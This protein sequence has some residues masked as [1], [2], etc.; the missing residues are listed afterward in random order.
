ML[1]QG[2]V[3][4]E[5]QLRVVQRAAI[6][7][8]D[9]DGHDHAGLFGGGTDGISGVRRHG[10]R[11]IQQLVVL[12]AHFERRLHEREIRVVRHDGFRK[13]GE[14]HTL[15]AEFENLLH[16]FIHGAFTAVEYGADLDGG[17]FYEGHGGDLIEEVGF[18]EIKITEIIFR[19]KCRIHHLLGHHPRLARWITCGGCP[20]A[21]INARRIRSR[22]PKPVSVA[23]TSME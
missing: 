2:A 21:R 10:H 16:D 8:V 12:G 1:D 3:G 6:A 19:L 18:S 5:Q 20:N 4:I 17:G 13:H 11:L 9:A 14:L 15:F 22:S 23:T 7:F